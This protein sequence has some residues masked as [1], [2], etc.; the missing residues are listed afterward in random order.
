MMTDDP[1]IDAQGNPRVLRGVTIQS[2]A[3]RIAELAA[4]VGFDT[5]WIELEHGSI[6]YG[7]VETLCMAVEAGGAVPA[8]RIQDTQRTHVLRALEA[9]ARIVLAP[10]VD[11]VEQAQE[12]VEYGKY[13]PLGRRGFNMSSRGLGYGVTSPVESFA[14]ANKRTHLFAQIESIEAA[15][16]VESICAVDGLAGIF[17][18]PGDLSMDMG[19]CA[20]FDDPEVI[21]LCCD[22]I[23]RARKAGKHAG[24][25]AAPGPLYAAAL[26]AGADLFYFGSDLG[27]LIKA[28]RGMLDAAG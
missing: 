25:M 19:K 2:N 24:I 13:A 20:Q 21:A 10:M 17:V 6:G 3:T 28:W 26:S 9:G 27:V 7:E 15:G 4:S 18:G 14:A 1:F 8:V 11:T 22:I 5:V 16:N 12:L 23:T